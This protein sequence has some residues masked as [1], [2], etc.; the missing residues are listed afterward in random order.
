MVEN[1]GTAVRLFLILIMSSV[2]VSA[3]AAQ[4]HQITSGQQLEIN[5]HAICKK[6][7][8]NNP[9]SIFVPTN[10]QTEWQAFLTNAS[11]VSILDCAATPDCRTGY[12]GDQ[13]YYVDNGGDSFCAN[14]G[15]VW[16]GVAVTI[17]G[18]YTVGPSLGVDPSSDDYCTWYAYQICKNW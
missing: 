9:L 16:A 12:Y 13:Y 8:N 17:G 1:T 7:T 15:G 5:E 3:N 11:N 10:S 6:V 18:Q 14:W 2:S 4:S